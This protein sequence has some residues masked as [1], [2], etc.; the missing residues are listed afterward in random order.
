MACRPT[1]KPT[2]L[3][4][5]WTLSTRLRK[6]RVSASAKVRGRAAAC[7]GRTVQTVLGTTGTKHSELQYMI[8]A[9]Y[10]ERS[11]TKTSN[12]GRKKQEH[13]AEAITPDQEAK[14]L[15]AVSAKP[16]VPERALTLVGG[17]LCWAVL[18]RKKTLENRSWRIKPGWYALHCSV[19]KA[20]NPW[21]LA[22]SNCEL[23]AQ[24][25][26]ACGKGLPT[27]RALEHFYGQLLGVVRIGK[28]RSYEACKQNAWAVRMESR[29]GKSWSHEI[30]DVV[31]LSTRGAFPLQGERLSWRVPPAARKKLAK[32]MA[33]ASRAS[34]GL[35][36][37]LPTKPRTLA[38]GHMAKFKVLRLPH[39]G[40]K[41]KARSTYSRVAL[42]NRC[43]GDKTKLSSLRAKLK[44][45]TTFLPIAN[46]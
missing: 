27:E 9:G 41:L 24:Q 18:H 4:N 23:T 46:K 31:D 34:K 10:L 1:H 37:R 32:L 6:G 38:S 33:C 5:G 12:V 44:D 11:G 3:P 26:A 42:E 25:R 14:E 2:W 35:S 16:T 17:Q 43:N 15:A 36:G 13:F 20:W 39:L 40:L 19:K 8:K 29:S 28:C 7:A 22:S 30:V 21:V 45:P